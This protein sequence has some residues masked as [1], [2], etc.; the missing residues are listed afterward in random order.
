MRR[1]NAAFQPPSAGISAF[2]PGV[3]DHA[4]NIGSL[5][6]DPGTSR[7]SARDP[8]NP[9]AFTQLATIEPLEQ[10]RSIPS[11]R[12]N[13]MPHPAQGDVDPPS[14]MVAGITWLAF[15]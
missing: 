12:A 10:L 4:R 8:L 1:A 9:H 5:H 15:N 2:P 3:P 13:G 11:R 14:T 6:A 7:S